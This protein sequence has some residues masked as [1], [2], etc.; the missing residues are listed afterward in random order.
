MDTIPKYVAGDLRPV[1][2]PEGA[3]YARKIE[4]A[5]GSVDWAEPAEV[6]ERKARAFTPWPGAF[7]NVEIGAKPRV[8]KI[9][10][11]AIENRSGS[12]GE[13]LSSDRHS[14]IIACGR[15]ALSLLEVQA[16]GRKRMTIQEFLSGHQITR[17]LPPS[18]H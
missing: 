8:L 14:L 1:P 9:W 17:T 11:V 12:P 4:K 15:D 13:I 16:E 7:A 5:D 2:Q 18:A 3:T 6:I 10:K